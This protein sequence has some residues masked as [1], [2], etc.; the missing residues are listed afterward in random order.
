MKKKKKKKKKST[1]STTHT[2]GI[3]T[4]SKMV[5]FHVLQKQFHDFLPPTQQL[6]I[7]KKSCENSLYLLPE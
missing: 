7:G 2:E 1:I 3:S 4:G 5:P 6:T